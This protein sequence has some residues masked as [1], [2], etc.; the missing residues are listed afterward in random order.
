MVG[1]IVGSGTVQP[2]NS[3]LRRTRAEAEWIWRP[4]GRGSA[5]RRSRATA[6]V[7]RP[8]AK[9]LTAEW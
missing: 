5:L 7:W 3:L 6:I 1:S 2:S 4:A 8:R 9:A